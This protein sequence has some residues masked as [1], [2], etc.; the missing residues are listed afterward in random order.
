MSRSD[1]ERVA[2]ILDSC[3]R[4]NEIAS[5]GKD[6]FFAGEILQDAAS[7]RL[8]VVGEAVTVGNSGGRRHHRRASSPLPVGLHLSV[9]AH[10]R[11]SVERN[12]R[13][14]TQLTEQLPLPQATLRLDIHTERHPLSHPL[15]G[16]ARLAAGSPPGLRKCL[17]CDGCAVSASRRSFKSSVAATTCPA[18]GGGTRS[19]EK[20][21]E[22]PLLLALSWVCA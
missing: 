6:E 9:S 2:D 10:K 17:C 7:Y 8:T 18:R 12:P 1:A 22:P 13:H 4:L 11:S 5:A 20:L 15:H 19:P 21:S 16:V 3:R 14:S